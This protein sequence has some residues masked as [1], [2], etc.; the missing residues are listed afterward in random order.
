[1]NIKTFLSSTAAVLVVL[2]AIFPPASPAAAQQEAVPPSGGYDDPEGIPRRAPTADVEPVYRG[3]AID[4]LATLR[5][6]GVLR[7]GVAASEPMVMR[8]QKGALVGF[9]VDLGR[10]LA[11]D[12]GVRLEIVETS[13]SQI[14]P[15]LLDRHFDIIVS[16]LWVTPERA[17]VVNY[18]DA[19][20][21]LGVHLVAGRPLAD[22]L[23]T[24]EDFNRPDVRIAVYAGTV[25]E[26][27]ARRIFPRA[28]LVTVTGDD[29]EMPPVLA[30]TAHAALVPT[31]APQ[32][33]VRS[34]PDKLF[35]PL[36]APVQTTT[37]AMA[38][39]KGDADFLNYLDSWLTIQRDDGWLDD[40]I[41]HWSA[42]T[43]GTE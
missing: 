35:L 25:Q 17:L 13:W 6:R 29:N 11:E 1:M 4:T 21:T 38:V 7:V 26:R 24:I 14:I 20:A 2:A 30:G 23:R 12:L 27:V 43:D 36:D 28:T 3:P 10:Q 5:K 16:G 34:A 19:T 22:G 32:V 37:T 33:L 39:R 18:T 8:D 41:A 15:D 9:S 40:R 42:A 31:F